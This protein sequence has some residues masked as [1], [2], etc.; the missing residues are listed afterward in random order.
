[1]GSFYF[2]EQSPKRKFGGKVFFKFYFKSPKWAK[3]YSLLA[4][5]QTKVQILFQAQPLKMLTKNTV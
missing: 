4:L 3:L 2:K 5:K 1:M